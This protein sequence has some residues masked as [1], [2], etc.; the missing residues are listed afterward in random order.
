MRCPCQSGCPSGCPCED[1]ECPATTSSSTTTT[2]LT[3]TI[4]TTTTADVSDRTEVLILNTY[5]PNVYGSNPPVITNASG[6]VD[7]NFE[8]LFGQ[9]TEVY[10]SCGLTWRGDFYVFGGY[11]KSLRI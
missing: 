6:R 8:F 3:T 7:K 2:A 5:Q 10:H 11:K 4:T 9:D 1:Y